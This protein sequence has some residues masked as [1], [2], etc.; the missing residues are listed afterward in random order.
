MSLAPENDHL[1]KQIVAAYVHRLFPDLR[2][3]AFLSCPDDL[4]AHTV[5]AAITQA[6]ASKGVA[7]DVIDLRSGP[8]ELLDRV[9]ERL[10]GFEGE[11]EG[12]QQSEVR[13]LALDGFDLLEGPDND[14]PTYPFRSKLQFDE[15]HLW[16]FLGRD[17]HRLSRLFSDYQL[18]LYNAAENLT[19]ALW[20]K[21]G[22]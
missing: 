3:P 6:A 17:W 16:L 5:L 8:Q 12:R 21:R 15:D 13:I 14:K 19:P 1:V 22:L 4:C 7:T 11:R 9:T 18:P 2:R 10:R 20:R